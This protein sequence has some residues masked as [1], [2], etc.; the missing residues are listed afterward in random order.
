MANADGLDV[1]FCFIASSMKSL[2]RA[3][4]RRSIS[5]ITDVYGKRT[6]PYRCLIPNDQ[7]GRDDAMSAVWVA[8][9]VGVFLGVLIGILVIALC[10]IAH[11][12]DGGQ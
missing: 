8:F 2:A 4:R 3:G 5:I 10:H 11:E 12:A 6:I 1:L 7:S 9:G